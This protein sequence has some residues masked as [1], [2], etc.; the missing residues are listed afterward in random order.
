[1]YDGDASNTI[2]NENIPAKTIR[3][4]FLVLNIKQGRINNKSVFKINVVLVPVLMRI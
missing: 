3:I 4:I 2:D 1:M